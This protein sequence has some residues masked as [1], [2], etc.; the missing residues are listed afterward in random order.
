MPTIE[1]RAAAALR[2]G[3]VTGRDAEILTDMLGRARHYGGRLTQKQAAFAERLIE[4]TVAPAAKVTIDLARINQMFDTAAQSLKRPFVNFLVGG[5]ELKMSPAPATG[6]NPGSLYV[7]RLGEYQGKIDRAGRFSAARDAQDG[8][9]EALQAFAANPAAA[10]LAYGQ[11]T[12]N[13]CFCARELTDA[14][15]VTAGYG[16]ICAEHYGLP[17]G[18]AAE[19]LPQAEGDLPP[20][21]VVNGIGRVA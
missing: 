2:S 14:R 6:K 10:A 13:C 17:W 1:E 16:P 3:S 21:I 20:V 9:L 8:I 7:K 11:A 12:G 19:E 5:V 4:P 18:Y 15:S